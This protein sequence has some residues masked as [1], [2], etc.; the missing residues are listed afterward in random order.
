MSGSVLDQTCGA[1]QRNTKRKTEGSF[2]TGRVGGSLLRQY[3]RWSS[4][5]R[6]RGKRGQNKQALGRSRGGFGTKV[7]VEA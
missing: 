3:Q 5:A 4:S 1:L 7:H 2:R 6:R